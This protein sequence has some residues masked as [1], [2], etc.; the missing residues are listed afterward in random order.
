[1][2]GK[3]T[4]ICFIPRKC[5]LGVWRAESKTNKKVAE[6]GNGKLRQHPILGHVFCFKFMVLKEKQKEKLVLQVGVGKERQKR[7]GRG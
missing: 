1:V 5:A 7:G 6:E 2:G 4:L 3:I